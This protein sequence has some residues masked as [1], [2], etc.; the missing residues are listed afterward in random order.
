MARFRKIDV[1]MWGDDRFRALSRPPP[2]GR[3]CWIHLLTNRE[4]SNIPGV[5]RAYEEGLARDLEWP[6]EAYREAFREALAQGMAEADW[7]AGLVFIPGALKHNQPESL[8][9]VKGWAA[10]WDELPECALKDKAFAH[11]SEYFKAKGMAWVMAWDKAS[12]KARANQEQEQEQEQ[13]EE[14]KPSRK[15]AP[16]LFELGPATKHSLKA[17]DVLALVAENSGGRFFAPRRATEKQ[18]QK[19]HAAVRDYPGAQEWQTLGEWLRAGGEQWKGLVSADW[20]ST[21]GVQWMPAA[22]A[23][24]K[25]GKQPIPSGKTG[26]RENPTEKRNNVDNAAATDALVGDRAQQLAERRK[27][28]PEPSAPPPSGSP[29]EMLRS[30]TAKFGA[31]P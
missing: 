16:P 30:L 3:D 24:S 17:S 11:Y 20:V 19:L 14:K 4:T 15:T 23:W 18:Q 28:R 10:V 7:Q 25:S 6:L 5:Y 21:D 9:V 8:N 27:Q 1:R 26:R 31:K 29:G 22:I 12:G 2:N 13:E